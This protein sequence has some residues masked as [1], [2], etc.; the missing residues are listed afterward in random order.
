MG[1]IRVALNGA[2]SLLEAQSE[3]QRKKSIGW[4][5]KSWIRFGPRLRMTIPSSSLHL[6]RILVIFSPTNLILLVGGIS[7][8]HFRA[9]HSDNGAP[10]RPDG[11]TPLRGFKASVWEGGYREPG[12]AWWPGKVK[13]GS[14]SDALVATYGKHQ[15]PFAH[16]S[17]SVDAFGY[18]EHRVPNALTRDVYFR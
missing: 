12:L 4:L 9:L 10:Q 1:R 16:V 17:P 7:N 14:A 6:V 2:D 18:A 13:A 3:M 5:N 11:N 8:H 15:H